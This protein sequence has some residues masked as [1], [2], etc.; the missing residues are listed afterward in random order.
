MQGVVRKPSAAVWAAASFLLAFIVVGTFATRTLL[1]DSLMGLYLG[2]FIT[3]E[4]IPRVDTLTVEGAGREW[5]DQ[6]WLSQLAYYGAWELGGYALVG[7]ASSVAFCLG[8]AL[9]AKVLHGRGVPGLQVVSWAGLAL[10]VCI[11]NTFIR[12]QSFAVPMFMLVIALLLAD[13]RARRFRWRVW[14]AILVTFVVWANVHGS[15]LL[16]IPFVS[17]YAAV[18]ALQSW[19]SDEQGLRRDAAGYAASAIAVPASILA[20]PYGWDIVAYYRK[21]MGNDTISQFITEWEPANFQASGSVPFLV[22]MAGLTI[23]VAYQWGRGLRPP[24][25]PLAM[26]IWFGLIG[27]QALRYHLWVAFPGVIL[28][29]SVLRLPTTDDAGSARRARRLLLPPAAVLLVAGLA[30]AGSYFTRSE[31]EWLAASPMREVEAAAD[32]LDEHADARI[33]ADD[34]SSPALLWL[35]PEQAAGRVAFDARLEHFAEPDLLAFFVFVEALG[36]E[37]LDVADG[38]DLVLVSKVFHP[39]AVRKLKELDGWRTL[40]ES[41]DGLLLLR[42]D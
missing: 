42:K 39:R 9:L 32:Y 16:T 31:A 12:A 35:H 10:V 19:R 11:N 2:R 13:D 7:L 30:L 26:T 40:E 21:V 28:L 3:K 37:W 18:R 23:A 4:G 34:P 17:A 15:L 27:T 41:D 8:F 33:L 22:F 5:I 25:L 38:Y 20:T 24:W 36:P 14:V 1:A 29:A 6:Q